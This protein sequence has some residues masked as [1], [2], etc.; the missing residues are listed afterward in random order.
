MGM[1]LF[2]LAL[3]AVNFN[4]MT[5]RFGTLFGLER[6][7]NEFLEGYS[8]RRYTVAAPEP[9]ESE[10]AA[11]VLISDV[12]GKVAAEDVWQDRLVEPLTEYYKLTDAQLKVMLLER[13][14]AGSDDVNVRLFFEGR[15]GEVSYL[16]PSTN[17]RNGWWTPPCGTEDDVAEGLSDDVCP[18]EWMRDYAQWQSEM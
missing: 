5:V 8:A 11:D 1:L 12:S 7:W 18:E 15:D 3:A 17:S 13:K 16:W 9:S 14:N 4:L 2:A 10:P 6:S